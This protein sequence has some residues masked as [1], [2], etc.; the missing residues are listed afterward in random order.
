MQTDFEKVYSK[1]EIYYQTMTLFYNSKSHMLM[2]NT[3][4]I[5]SIAIIKRINKHQKSCNTWLTKQL[6]RFL[7]MKEQCYMNRHKEK[8]NK[9]RF[10][11]IDKIVSNKKINYQMSP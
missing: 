5:T 2:T 4:I 3:I 6:V 11:K 8:I 7:P 9:Y 1:T 10:I